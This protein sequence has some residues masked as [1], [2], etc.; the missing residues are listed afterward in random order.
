M[1]GDFI[2]RTGKAPI[3]VFDSGVGGISVLRE[4]IALMPQENFYYYGDSANAPYGTKGLEEVRKLTIGHVDQFIREGAK[5]VVVACNTATSAAVRLLRLKYGDVPI[6]GIEPALKPAV[7]SKENPNVVVM[8]TPMTIREE[9]FHNLMDR[10]T[11][12]AHIIP[13]PCPGLME[14]IEQGNIQGEELLA[15]LDKLFDPF[16]KQK[17]DAVVLGCTHYPFVSRELKKVLGDKVALFDGG[18]GVARE[19]RRRL[20]EKGLLGQE[21]KTGEI[22]FVNSENTQQ[23]IRLCKKLLALPR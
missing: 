12:M 7:L 10:Y 15:F 11:H 21:K 9:K 19:T 18:E 2:K 3:A 20:A 23:K 8:A 14:Y 22:L 6:I 5:A 17:L 1:L 13:L 4:L 16:D